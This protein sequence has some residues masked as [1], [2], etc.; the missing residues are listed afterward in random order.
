M[1]NAKSVL[2]VSGLS[3]K[4]GKTR[5]LENID[6]SVVPGDITCV[7]GP[8]GAGKS[9]LFSAIVCPDEAGLEIE[10]GSI[11][12]MGKNV[13]KTSRAWIATKL[14]LVP[15][16]PDVSF[17]F[18][19]KD[20]VQMARVPYKGLFG[21]MNP[22][23]YDAVDRA[24]AFTDVKKYSSRSMYSLSG[25]ELQRVFIARALA[26]EPDILLLDETTSNLDMSSSI[27]V[28]E[29]LRRTARDTGMAVLII[30]HDL[31]LAASYCTKALALKNGKVYRYGV[32]SDVF[33]SSVL[34]GLMDSSM[35][36]RQSDSSGL[37]YLSALPESSL[38]IK[39]IYK[40]RKVHLIAGGGRVSPYMMALAG[41]DLDYSISPVCMG[42]SDWSLAKDLDIEFIEMPSFAGI[43][44][45]LLE[46][47]KELLA[48][49][50]ILVFPSV[51]IGDANVAVLDMCEYFITL[52]KAQQ[53]EN[54][55][56]HSM[57]ARHSIPQ[58]ELWVEMSIDFKLRN[59]SGRESIKRYE[60]LLESSVTKTYTNLD[61][62]L[63]LISEE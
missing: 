12:I 33:K 21:T 25:G 51:A 46:R 14:A 49:C 28:M 40:N 3:I 24:M 45:H 4:R 41:S 26:Q 20:I 43:D 15:Q 61:A 37:T 50:D 59:Y 1:S 27:E 48:S 35:L 39:S 17:N 7:V 9:T 6:L 10:T 32:V 22:E 57:N 31:N 30:F 38:K 2:K 63:E 19:V 62:F 58:K 18:S 54:S 34:T 44:D 11:E 13:D 56:N 5:I 42:D 8:N 29:I 52:A 23:D 36:V 47:E 60:K 16:K 55:G 53:A